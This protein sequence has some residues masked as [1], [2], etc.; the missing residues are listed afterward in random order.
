MARAGASSTRHIFWRP[1]L[2]R[3]ASLNILMTLTCLYLLS[4]ELHFAHVTMRGHWSELT[5]AFDGTEWKV[6][7]TGQKC[8]QRVALSLSI[9]SRG[10]VHLAAEYST[11]HCMASRKHQL[12]HG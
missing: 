4:G 11:K 1:R 12:K 8:R 3:N 7:N 2:E 10:K 9:H 5:A 6:T